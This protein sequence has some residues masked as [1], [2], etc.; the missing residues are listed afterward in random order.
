MYWASCHWDII[1]AFDDKTAARPDHLAYLQIGATPGKKISAEGYAYWSPALPTADNAQ[2][3]LS[4]WVRL[5]EVKSTA[6]NGGLFVTAEFSDITGQHV[7]RQY[8]AGADDGQKPI[9]PTG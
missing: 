3:D 6:D 2:I 1:H 9:G 4:L 8:L 7:T 5:K